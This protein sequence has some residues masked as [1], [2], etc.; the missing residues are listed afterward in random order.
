MNGFAWVSGALN[1]T[2]T[3]GKRTPSHSSEGRMV[4]DVVETQVRAIATDPVKVWQ[5]AD[6]LLLMADQSKGCTRGD[7]VIAACYVIY[8]VQKTCARKASV[9]T[10]AGH[11]TRAT[12][13]D[14]TLLGQGN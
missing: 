4:A 13:K 11:N 2:Y 10:K 1:P 3:Y 8:L 7:V 5:P 12:K 6:V 14:A 9:T